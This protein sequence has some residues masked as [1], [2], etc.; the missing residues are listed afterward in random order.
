MG[1]G[2]QSTSEACEIDFPVEDQL[3]CAERFIE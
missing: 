3:V 1:F 2:E